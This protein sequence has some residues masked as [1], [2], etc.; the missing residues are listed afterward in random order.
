MVDDIGSTRGSKFMAF[1][2][3]DFVM[4]QYGWLAA[5]FM[6]VSCVAYLLFD[7]EDESNMLLRNVG[8]I[9]QDYTVLYTRRH[10]SSNFAENWH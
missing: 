2:K 6:L 1:S 5:C 8:R 7:P 9:L 4:D 10:D 3:L